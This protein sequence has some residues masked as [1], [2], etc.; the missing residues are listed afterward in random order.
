MRDIIE[1]PP[2]RD[3]PAPPLW[4]RIAWFTGLALAGVL[5]TAGIA[6]ALKLLL[7]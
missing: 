2:Q 5:S 7:R 3:D 4:R 1:R 6:F